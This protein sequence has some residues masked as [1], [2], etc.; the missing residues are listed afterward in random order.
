M[1]RRAVLQHGG[2]PLPAFHTDPHAEGIC[3]DLGDKAGAGE[4][5]EDGESGSTFIHA[6][7]LST[8]TLS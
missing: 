8:T 6:G 1:H 7:F 5:L 4:G 3:N 2:R